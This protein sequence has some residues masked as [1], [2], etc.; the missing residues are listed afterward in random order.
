MR[1]TTDITR[2]ITEGI[3]D[4]KGRKITHLDLSGIE[5]A[6]AS[7]FIICEGTSTM[8]VSAIA[9]NIREHLLKEAGIKPYNYDGYQNAQW[10]VI[11]YGDTLVHVFVPET[12]ERYNIEELWNDA[13]V[14]EIPDLL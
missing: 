12:R 11:D 14:T 8:Q 13:K 2:L 9:D 10:I 5:T 4:R 1:A 7:N 3:Q 6:A